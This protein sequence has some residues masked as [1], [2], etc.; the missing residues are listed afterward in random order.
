VHV[1]G[2]APGRVPWFAAR[3]VLDRPGLRALPGLRFARFL[4]T[5]R[6]RSFGPWDADWRHWAL[7]ATWS[8]PGYAAA[9]DRSALVRRR[10]AASEERLSLLLEPVTW[11]GRWDGR[12]PFGT[13]DAHGEHRG[14]EPVAAL[15]RARLAPG[16]Y[17]AFRRAVRDVAAELGACPGKVIAIGV[18]ENP[19]GRQGTFSV[20]RDA[21]AMRAFA[22]GTPAHRRAVRRTPRAG[23]YT[24]ELFA[25][26]RVL[27]MSGSHARIAYGP[28]GTAR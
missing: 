20:W 1:W 14:P 3:S 10:D 21:D 27:R 17:L 15:T 19:F 9:F 24:E 18:G 25:T 4:G 16:G 13:A 11:R 8:A 23:W 6:G 26:F 7:F 28:A 2:A 5:G 22:R 12:A